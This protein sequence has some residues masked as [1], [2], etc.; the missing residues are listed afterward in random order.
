M[1]AGWLKKVAPDVFFRRV[2]CVATHGLVPLT[3][4]YFALEEAGALDRLH[5]E[6]YKA[7]HEQSINSAIERSAQVDGNE[8][9]GARRLREDPESESV[10]REVQKARD[11]T[12]AY[13]I[14][15]HRPWWWTASI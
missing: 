14:P 3:R 1:L 8:R 11:T 6:V 5:G 2:P 9:I 13:G 10:E 15:R 7:I 12:V 4:L